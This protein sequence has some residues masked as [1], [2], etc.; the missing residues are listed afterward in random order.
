MKKA[1]EIINE[2]YTCSLLKITY[3][4]GWWILCDVLI[5]QWLNYEELA[6]GWVNTEVSSHKIIADHPFLLSANKI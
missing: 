1:P 3:K 4:Q 2:L 6:L 5:Q